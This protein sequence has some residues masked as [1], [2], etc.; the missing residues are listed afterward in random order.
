MY[1]GSKYIYIYINVFLNSALVGS[2]WFASRSGRFALGVRASGTLLIEDWLG[3]SGPQGEGKILP[4]PRL[5]LRTLGSAA[6]SQ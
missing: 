3:Q 5:K 6:R 1:G 2:E 4:L